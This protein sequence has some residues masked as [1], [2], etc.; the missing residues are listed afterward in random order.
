MNITHWNLARNEACIF[1]TKS[2]SVALSALLLAG[3]ATFFSSI[4]PSRHAIDHPRTNDRFRPFRIIDVN[5]EV[6]RR[7]V[8]Q[9]S[10]LLFSEVFSTH[11]DQLLPIGQA[12]S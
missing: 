7:L 9:R 5:E 10:R 8:A 6:T 11:P 12:I 4:G 2:A 3:C 1:T